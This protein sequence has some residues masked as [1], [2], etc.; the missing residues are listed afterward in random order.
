VYDYQ[1]SYRLAKLYLQKLK[2]PHKEFISFENSAHSPITEEYER[3][4]EAVINIVK[5]HTHGI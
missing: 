2:A 1:V 4:N 3:F 5:E